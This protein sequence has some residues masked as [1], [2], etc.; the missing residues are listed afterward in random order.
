M[1][2]VG[3]YPATRKDLLSVEQIYCKRRIFDAHLCKKSVQNGAPHI[4]TTTLYIRLHTVHT[5][6]S[7]Y[8]FLNSIAVL[9]VGRGFV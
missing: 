9:V 1:Y 8:D 6:H 7:M 5:V 2:H 3:T 4:C